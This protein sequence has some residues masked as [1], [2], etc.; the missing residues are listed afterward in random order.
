MSRAFRLAPFSLHG[1]LRSRNQALNCGLGLRVHKRRGQVTVR[2]HDL[3][4]DA[5]AFAK[6]SAG[7]AEA[8]TLFPFTT[9][10]SG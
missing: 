4:D 2:L 7:G 3:V 5:P 8:A 10:A 1:F 6:A 9:A